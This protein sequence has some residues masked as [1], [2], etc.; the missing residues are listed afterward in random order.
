MVC[1]KLCTNPTCNGDQFLLLEH[2]PVYV[3]LI[4]VRLPFLVH[5]ISALELTVLDIF[6]NATKLNKLVISVAGVL[7]DLM[8]ALKNMLLHPYKVGIQSDS[9]KSF[10]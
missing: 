3:Y 6:P 9:P 4:Q 5:Y 1:I 8:D 2:F 10:P 7:P